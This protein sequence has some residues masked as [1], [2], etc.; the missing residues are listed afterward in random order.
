MTRPSQAGAPGGDPF[1]RQLS[2]LL[3]IAAIALCWPL[4]QLQVAPASRFAFV[5]L[6][7]EHWAHRDAL[8]PWLDRRWAWLAAHGYHRWFALA[9][10]PGVFAVALVQAFERRSGWPLLQAPL[11]WACGGA[12]GML[13]YLDFRAESW[14]LAVPMPATFA[15]LGGAIGARLGALGRVRHLRGTRLAPA[16]SGALGRGWARLTGG[17]ALAGVP[18]GRAD[19]TMHVAV[20]G[21]TGSG[22]SSAL[23]ALMADALRRGDRQLVA[24]PEGGAMAAFRAPGDII[25]NPFDARCARWDLLAEIER[26]ADFAFLATSLLPHMGQGDHDQWISYAQQLLAGAMENFWT[27]KLGTSDDFITMLASARLGELRQLCAGTPSARYFEEGGER[28]LAS[29]LGTLA[30]A[31]GHL[32]LIAGREGAPFSLRRWIREGSG[33]LWMPYAANETAALRGLISCWTN[34]A[35]FET[36]SLAPSA[37]R[38]IWFQVDELDALG[39]IEGL[40]DGLARLRKFGGCVALG[41]QSYAQLRQIY[42]EGAETIIENCGNLLLLRSGLSDDGGTAKLAS[43]LIGSREVERH[44]VSRSRSRGRYLSRSMTIQPRRNVEEVILP[45]EIMQLSNREGFVKRAGSAEWRRV[46]FP[47]HGTSY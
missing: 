6:V 23:R 17:V 19:E 8:A 26:P 21:A 14:P 46:R 5:D 39:R 27:L 16:W 2:L 11:G 42:G 29:I 20:I 22:K 7:A 25:L 45:S 38:R 47:F 43:E 44:D 35:I 12:L 41:F 15:F 34:I 3:A 1:T 4:I 9:M 37:E 13:L 33:S 28:M 10:L 40:K 32:R 18:L 36:L 24:D 30:P 31:V